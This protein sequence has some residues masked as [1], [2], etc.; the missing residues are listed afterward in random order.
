MPARGSS[1]GVHTLEGRQG[2]SFEKGKLRP[3]DGQSWPVRVRPCEYDG[4]PLSSGSSSGPHLVS[5][6]ELC[7]ECPQVTAMAEGDHK[8]DWD[9]NVSIQGSRR[10]KES[11]GDFLLLLDG[12]GFTSLLST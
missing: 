5:T 9:K 6:D 3:A 11:V 2:V 10:R 4:G 1:G 12:T 7:R 8:V